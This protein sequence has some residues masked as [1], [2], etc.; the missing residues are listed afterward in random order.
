M[1]IAEFE[2]GVKSSKFV[3]K[4]LKVHA[5]L[6]AHVFDGSYNRLEC[7]FVV[8]GFFASQVLDAFKIGYQH[9]I[10]FSLSFNKKSNVDGVS[11]LE[12]GRS[13]FFILEQRNDF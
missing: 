13:V 10:N 3:L 1:W 4:G 12:S 7:E 9:Y 2:F 11:F 8:T 6:K 5:A